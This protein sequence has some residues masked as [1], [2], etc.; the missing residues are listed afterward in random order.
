MIQ[1]VIFGRSGGAARCICHI[2]K[3]YFS[4][5]EAVFVIFG[6]YQVVRQA[7]WESL[8]TFTAI[9][10]AACHS[11]LGGEVTLSSVSHSGKCGR[12]LFSGVGFDDDRGG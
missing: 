3:L 4:Y 6:I 2:G 12:D 9:I 10:N 8:E 5:W 7:V 11:D 1:F